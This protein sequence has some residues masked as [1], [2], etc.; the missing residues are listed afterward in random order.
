L[1]YLSSFLYILFQDWRSNPHDLRIRLVLV[2]FRLAGWA[3]R[4]Q[5][6]LR[7]LFCPY[8]VLY[9]A[10]VFWLFHMELHC[11]LDVGE[12]LRIHHGYCLVI[13]PDVRIGKNVSLL[14][15]VTLGNKR[16]AT[17]VPTLEDYVEVGAHAT[18]IGPV[19]IGKH[20]IVGA[21]AVVTN[22]VPAGAIVAG[23]PAK[24]ISHKN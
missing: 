13:H 17:G 19:I 16:P 11:N 21:G 7:I 20:A 8:L 10:V 2:A 22:D 18:I 24:I 6:V 5:R 12:G 15:G 4:R 23:N 14:H 1:L 3:Q 9:R